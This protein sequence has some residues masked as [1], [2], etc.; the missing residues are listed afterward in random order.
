MKRPQPPP[1]TDD[2]DRVFTRVVLSRHA[3]S[4]LRCIGC[5]GSG[6]HSPLTRFVFERRYCVPCADRRF[7]RLGPQK[8]IVEM[9]RS[10]DDR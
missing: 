2:T 8:P 10:K 6:A 5:S 1:T 9:R 4:D 7:A 3:V